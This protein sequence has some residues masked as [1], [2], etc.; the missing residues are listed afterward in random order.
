MGGWVG[1]EWLAVGWW[2]WKHGLDVE[3]TWVVI[4]PD[5]LRTLRVP[6]RACHNRTSVLVVA[7]VQVRWTGASVWAPLASMAVGIVV[8]A[9]RRAYHSWILC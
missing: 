4:D 6:K 2:W 7:V 3:R 1:G 5:K 9:W 8:G